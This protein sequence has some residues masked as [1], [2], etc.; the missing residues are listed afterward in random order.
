[1]GWGAAGDES[2][3]IWDCFADG[4]GNFID[5]ADGYTNGT[6]EKMVGEFAASNREYFAPYFQVDKQFSTR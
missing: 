5:T 6:S 1:M 3:R 4:D 2:R